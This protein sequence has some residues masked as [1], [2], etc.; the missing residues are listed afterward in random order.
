MFNSRSYAQIL[1]LFEHESFLD[2]KKLETQTKIFVNYKT[3]IV[4]KTNQRVLTQKQLNLVFLLFWHEWSALQS[5]AVRRSTGNDDSGHCF[6]HYFPPFFF[7]H[8]DLF[9]KKECSDQKT[10]LVNG[11]AQKPRVRRL[12]RPRRP[13]WVPLGA[14]FDFPGGSMFFIEGVLRSKNLLSES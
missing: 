13:F 10:Y 5:V 3:N 11:S 9:S 4:T 7:L 1:C 6:H 8:H 14:N 12:S 2:Q